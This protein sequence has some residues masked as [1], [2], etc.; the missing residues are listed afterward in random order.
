MTRSTHRTVPSQLDIHAPS[1]G[2]Q[3]SPVCS[4]GPEASRSWIASPAALALVA[5]G[6]FAVRCDAGDSQSAGGPYH[7]ESACTGT[8]GEL[9]TV[10]VEFVFEEN[11]WENLS[12]ESTRAF[13]TGTTI[14]FRTEPMTGADPLPNH[15]ATSSN[16]A[17]LTAGTMQD[18]RF[19]HRLSFLTA[20]TASVELKT[21]PQG[22]LLDRVT[23]RVRDPETIGLWAGPL[24]AEPLYIDGFAAEPTRILVSPD[25]GARLALLLKDSAGDA[26]IG[27]WEPTITIGPALLAVPEGRL[28]VG[29]EAW[30]SIHT[31]ALLGLGSASV[32]ATEHISLAGPGGLERTVEVQLDATPLLSR[33]SLVPG[34]YY[35]IEPGSVDSLQ[36]PSARAVVTAGT[37][38]AL[39]AIGWTSAG[40]PA[41]GYAVRYV[42]SNPMVAALT[43]QASG[44]DSI[45]VDFA[46][47]GEAVLTAILQADPSVRKQLRV[48]VVADS[49]PGDR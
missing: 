33:M 7:K 12:I 32:P 31:V 44:D 5:I 10:E 39:S 1:S 3:G 34:F 8:T 18:Q 15:E 43:S 47:P 2:H 42:S 28:S 45:H 13:A 48:L 36:D 23:L 24:D 19:P 4:R 41:L 17:V 30:V 37:S 6:L 49:P 9:G 21:V 27:N 11:P 25:G 35:D 46:R 14:G 16:P 29:Q 22:D 20:G 40:E 38:G 26:L